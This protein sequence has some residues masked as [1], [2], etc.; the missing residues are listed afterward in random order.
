MRAEKYFRELFGRLGL[1][2]HPGKVEVRG[3]KR[4]EIIGILVD[5]ERAQFALQPTKM[6]KIEG[7]ARRTL[8]H[9][10]DHRPYLNKKEVWSFYGLDNSSCLAVVD[11]RIR[12]RDFLNALTN[13]V[14]PRGLER[15]S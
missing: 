4:L 9:A 6:A 10:N 15:G 3:V 7:R 5:T 8:S 2:L 11:A 12:L 1:A 14:G 13:L